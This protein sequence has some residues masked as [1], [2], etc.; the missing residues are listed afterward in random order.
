MMFWNKLPNEMKIMLI[1]AHVPDML[2]KIW[3][4]GIVIRCVENID[5]LTVRAIIDS[6]DLMSLEYLAKRYAW[7]VNVLKRSGAAYSTRRLL[8][9]P[10]FLVGII[11][12]LLLTVY[13]P[14]KI[15]FV[16]V[17]GNSRV[18]DSMILSAAQECGVTF[19]ASRKDIRSEKIKNGL[20]AA[21]PQLQW[22]GVNSAGCVATIQVKERSVAD[23]EDTER[24][25]CSIVASKDAVIR[26]CDVRNGSRVCRIGQAVK[27]GQ[28][29]VSGYVDCGNHI[30]ATRADAEIFGQT[31][32]EL[33]VISPT[34]TS[35]RGAV[36]RE[37]T[38]YRLIIGKKLIKL[39]KD[40]GISGGSCVK[41]KTQYVL[42]LPGGFSLPIALERENLTYYDVAPVARLNEDAFVWLDG[43]ARNYL[44]D[45]MVA[46]SIVDDTSNFSVADGLCVL[47]GRYQCL[48]MIGK[49][50]TEELFNRYE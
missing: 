35:V 27:E 15:L 1:C 4:S 19:G 32:R 36:S 30:R 18:A 46:G 44:L 10:V 29:L 38:R 8:K 20:L 33:T 34:D 9:R 17:E 50:H 47:R 48:E 7:K 26:S 40:S 41:M 42:T 25:V 22:V 49:V 12:I 16:T 45:Q 5:P 43:F 21:I 6:S 3:E 39:Y 28:L 37:Q 14:G 11:L 23:T 2:Q 13:L 31:Q 24:G